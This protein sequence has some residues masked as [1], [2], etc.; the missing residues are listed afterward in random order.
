MHKVIKALLSAVIS[1]AFISPATA[2]DHGTAA[3]ANAM[4]KKA[5][6][7][8]RTHGKEKLYSEV[9]SGKAPFVD[10]D[11]YISI[12]DKN[13]KVLAHGANPKLV[14]KDFSDVKDVDG[15]PFMKE[16]VSKATSEGSGWVDYK[17]E[18]PLDKE[19]QPKSAYFEKL[20]DI[21]ISSGYYKK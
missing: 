4:V 3:E 18:N 16:I 13:A 1:I 8:A 20:D 11:L 7:F 19:V 9:S 14:G 15:K 5:V 10:R 12:W 17:W 2:G 21:I 6:E